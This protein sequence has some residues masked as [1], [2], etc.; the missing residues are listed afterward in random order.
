MQRKISAGVLLLAGAAFGVGQSSSSPGA[1]SS[2]P[3]ES[4][5]V[6]HAP[7]PIEA[8]AQ[9]LDHI[10]P[11]TGMLAQRLTEASAGID[12][13]QLR[14]PFHAAPG[15]GSQSTP[16]AL[17]K[18]NADNFSH[19]HNLLA[20]MRSSRGGLAIVD[21]KTVRPGQSIDS[22]E[23]VRVTEHAAVF[24]AAGRTVELPLK[25]AAGHLKEG[26]SV[27]GAVQ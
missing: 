25:E 8:Q 23:L 3:S 6:A 26:D 27:K 5:L 10:A 19:Q 15:W 12:A 4:L 16:D 14:D 2:A 20:V 21:G 9:T 7:A 1:V 13:G 24:R 17:A 22:F 18:Q 11:S